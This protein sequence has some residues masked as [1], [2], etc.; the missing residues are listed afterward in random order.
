M[1][2]NSAGSQGQM[3][4]CDLFKGTVSQEKVFKMRLL[5]F[6][7]GPTDVPHPLITSVHS[8]FNLLRLFKDEVKRISPLCKP[9]MHVTV[10][11][12]ELAC[13]RV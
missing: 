13:M 8:P 4:F 11:V 7:L 2:T 10:S 1:K 9:R 12:Q 3:L 5:G 6:R